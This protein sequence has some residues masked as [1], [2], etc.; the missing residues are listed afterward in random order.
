M[1]IQHLMQRN[2]VKC[3]KKLIEKTQGAHNEI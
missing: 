2:L 3:Y 1:L